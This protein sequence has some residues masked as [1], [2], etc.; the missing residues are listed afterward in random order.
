M[1][2]GDQVN[3]N[4]MALGLALATLALF[5]VAACNQSPKSSYERYIP[6]VARAEAALNE[7]LTAWKDGQ[8]V[9]TLKLEAEAVS[10]EVADSTRVPGQRL[11][12]YELLGEISGEGPRTFVVKLKLENPVAEREVRYYLVGI[13]PLWVFQ[14]ADY[15]ALIHWEACAERAPSVASQHAHN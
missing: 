5:G 11:V 13:D 3:L 15:D 12:G 4:R 9:G 14:Q 8:P 2:E 10:V 7:V 6:S 1:H